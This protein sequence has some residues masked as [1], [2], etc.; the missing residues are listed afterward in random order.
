LD[1]EKSLNFN[2]KMANLQH[3]NGYAGIVREVRK[4]IVVREVR[5]KLGRMLK[6]IK[7]SGKTEAMREN[8]SFPINSRK[9][10]FSSKNCSG[11]KSKV[12]EEK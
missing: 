2:F 3:I 12:S 4:K 1:T 8:T 6:C 5:L 9:L 7:K 10:L 11:K